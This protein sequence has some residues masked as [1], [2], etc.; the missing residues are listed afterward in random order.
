[1]KPIKTPSAAASVVPAVEGE[2]NLFL[3]IVCIIKPAILKADAE[4]M[5]TVVLGVLLLKKIF[6]A[7]LSPLNSALIVTFELTPTNN[8]VIVKSIKIVINI[9]LF[10]NLLPHFLF[11]F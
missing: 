4:S 3:L 11:S 8:E 9:I 5:I 1:M 2:I 6:Q 10:F 7:S